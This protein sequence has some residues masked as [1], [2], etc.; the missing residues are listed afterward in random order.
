MYL[1]GPITVIGLKVTAGLSSLFPGFESDFIVSHSLHISLTV[2]QL[3]SSYP[4]L[5]L[6]ELVDF[7]CQFT[8]DGL[9]TLIRKYRCLGTS[10]KITAVLSYFSIR[11]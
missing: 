2:L 1:F 4:L 9:I 8:D 7:Q 5:L 10:L 3:S 6:F 11:E